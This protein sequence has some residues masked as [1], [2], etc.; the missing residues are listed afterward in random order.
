MLFDPVKLKCVLLGMRTYY[1]PSKLAR[2]N[3]ILVLQLSISSRKQKIK[4]A[5]S[6]LVFLLVALNVVC[7]CTAMPPVG[8]PVPPSRPESF[9]NVEQYLAYIQALNAY[10]TEMTKSRYVISIDTRLS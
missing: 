5:A 9:D 7:L 6:A 2:G 1:N 10:M 3:I 8:L 4:M